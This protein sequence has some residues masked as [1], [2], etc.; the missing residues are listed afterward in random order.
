MFDTVSGF[1]RMNLDIGKLQGFKWMPQTNQYES[2]YFY[3]GRIKVWYY[4]NRETLRFE[5]SLPKLMFGTNSRLV[6]EKDLNQVQKIF[7]VEMFRICGVMVPDLLHWFPSRVD[8]CTHYY[9]PSKEALKNCLSSLEKMSLKPYIKYSFKEETE[10]RMCKSANFKFYIKGC[11]MIAH[12]ECNKVTEELLRCLRFEV[13]IRR[14]KIR[15]KY[16]KEFKLKDIL[17]D[18]V[19]C[20]FLNGYL[21]RIRLDSLI[22]PKDMLFSKIDQNFTERIA[23]KLKIF[24]I[25][26]NILGMDQTKKAYSDRTYYSYLARMR[27]LDISPFYIEDGLSVLLTA[28]RAIETRK[29]YHISYCT[30]PPPIHSCYEPCYYYEDSGG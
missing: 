25:S 18:E 17:K 8:F 6:Y 5:T 14:N 2:A 15:Q 24:I 4:P 30:F 1:T 13:C 3:T 29:E 28:R 10:F 22:M 20:S 19:A 16:G 21:K 7:K 23:K 27:E 9:F 26:L 11:E 12:G